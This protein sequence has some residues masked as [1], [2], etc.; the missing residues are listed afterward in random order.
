MAII[1][2]GR[3]ELKRAFVDSIGEIT[4]DSWPLPRTNANSINIGC[5]DRTT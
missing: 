5:E 3:Q 4:G 1:T 2:I